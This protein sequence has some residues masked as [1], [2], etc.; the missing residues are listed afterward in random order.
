MKTQ[1][2]IS[3]VQNIR[4]LLVIKT[5]LNILVV[6][7]LFILGNCENGSEGESEGGAG[8]DKPCIFVNGYVITMKNL[9]P[10]E[11]EFS[12]DFNKYGAGAISGMKSLGTQFAHDGVTHSITYSDVK[13]TTSSV[14]HAD[15]SIDNTNYSYPEDI[16]K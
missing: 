12:T 4:R 8:Q 14:Q 3:L 6:S 16:C 15:I 1:H 11:F 13:F 5:S 9:Y 7:L 2:S 10:D